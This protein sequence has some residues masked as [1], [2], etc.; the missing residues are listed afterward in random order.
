MWQTIGINQLS[1]HA[2]RLVRELGQ[3]IECFLVTRNHRDLLAVITPSRGRTAKRRS[4]GMREF[5]R[6]T[7]TV[8]DEVRASGEPV[9]LTNRGRPVGEIVPL[10]PE[11][12]ARYAAEMAAQSRAFLRSLEAADRDLE[13]GDAKELKEFIDSLPEDEEPEDDDIPAQRRFK[14]SPHGAV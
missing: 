13:T 4:V 7:F 8:L 3:G 6:C 1:I 14:R 12:Q 11:Q 2:N 5:S 9:T 10:T